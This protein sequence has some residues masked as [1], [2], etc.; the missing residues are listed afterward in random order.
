LV[1]GV[2]SQPITPEQ[3]SQNVKKV[4]EYIKYTVR[5]VKETN[6]LKEDSPTNGPQGTVSNDKILK[7]FH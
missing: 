1:F 3:V 5:K 7:S 6:H 4:N 2:T